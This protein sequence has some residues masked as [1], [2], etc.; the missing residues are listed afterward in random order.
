SGPAFNEKQPQQS[1]LLDA[2]S[3]EGDT[4]MPPDGKLPKAQRDIL[5]K[6]ILAGAYWPAGSASPDPGAGGLRSGPISDEDRQHWAYLPVRNPPVPAVEQA[7]WPTTDIDR[8]IL[9]RLEAEQL[10]PVADAERLALLRRVTFDLT[11]LPPTPAEIHSFQADDTAE[12]WPRVVDRLLASPHY[13]ER[14]GR[15]WLDLA[16]YADTAGD[17]ADYPIRE[18][19]KYRNYVID[20]LNAD[21]PYDRFLQEQIAGD[22]LAKQAAENGN[23]SPAEYAELVKATGYIAVTKRFGYNINT[24]FQHLDIADTLETLGRS[25]LGLSIGCAR[26]HDHKYDAITARDYYALYGIFSSTSYSFP[27]G[28]E[29]KKPHNLVPLTT[30]AEQAVAKQ[31]LDAR[32]A[33]L[34]AEQAEIDR[35]RGRITPHVQTGVSRDPG[36]ELQQTGKPGGKP[37]LAAGPNTILA[38]AQSPFSHVLPVGSQGIRFGTGK[39]TDGIRQEFTDVTVKQTPR[40]H[41]NIDF[42][43]VSTQDGKGSYRFYLGRGAIQSLAI[44]MSV[45]ADSLRVRNGNAFQEV[46]QLKT[47][48]WYNLQLT[49]DMAT[50]TFSGRIGSPGDMVEFTDF[51]AAPGWDGVFNTFV[52]DGFGQTPGPVPY[53]DV[54]NVVGQL[55]PFAPLPAEPAPV[56]AT[57]TNEELAKTREQLAALEAR[58]KELAARRQ[59]L[60]AEVTVPV[61]YGVMEGTPANTRLQLRGEPLR[62]AEEV[63]RGFLE[64]LGGE[65]LPEDATGSGR[66]QL[67]QWLTDPANPLTARVMTNRVWQQLLGRGL[68]NTPSDFGV[69]GELPSHPELLDH[70]ATG[71]MAD[72]WSLKQLV[73]R[74][75]LSRVYRLAAVE[76]ASH[77]E[78]DPA[79]TLFGRHR[80]RPLDAESIRDAMLAVSGDLNPD[81]GGPHPFPDVSQWKYTIHYPFHAVYDSDHRSVYL[82]IQRSRRHPFLQ[83]F[84]AADP[85]ISTAI[86]GTTITPTQSLYLM[87]SP[88]VHQRSASFAKRVQ[89]GASAETEQIALAFELTFNRPPTE[90][91]AASAADFLAR[92]RQMLPASQGGAANAEAAWSALARVLMTS[93]GFLYI[94]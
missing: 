85:N 47:G 33:V 62:L 55:E 89:S 54:D 75:V 36:W 88:F 49:V 13:G 90:A 93:N 64:I 2:I 53:R 48:T 84:D 52:C 80:R 38:E 32:L 67:A 81:Q 83:L 27:G 29:H 20:S 92:Y 43:T 70:L 31:K 35:E 19:W 82:M 72:G 18:A 41:F 23:I 11:G 86:R 63:P 17:G 10:K 57:R 3:Y 12:A 34:D 4:Q 44:E 68:V 91:E 65:T 26:C 16:R 50:K 71:F 73:R 22:I 74:I 87:N 69:R 46:R 37:W 7:D 25:V 28:E 42:R 60:M 78:H 39:Q 56:A 59:Q 6:W 9:A 94:D 24:E 8:F 51:A 1:R 61:A 77:V 76:E 45:D 79:N 14:W 21:K 66:L 58:E 30:P 40:F 15:H 5:T